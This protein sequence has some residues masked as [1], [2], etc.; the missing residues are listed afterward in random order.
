M[1]LVGIKTKIDI[2]KII[3]FYYKTKA[4]EMTNNDLL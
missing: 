3:L 1:F 4:L 2:W